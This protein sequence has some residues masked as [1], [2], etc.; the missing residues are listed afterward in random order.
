MPLPLSSPAPD[1][2]DLKPRTDLPWQVTANPDGSSRVFDLD[3]G[4]AT[5]GDA[6]AKFGGLEGLALFEPADGPRVRGV[7]VD[8]SEPHLPFPSRRG[9]S[10]SWEPRRGGSQPL[11]D[12][13]R[14]K[15]GLDELGTTPRR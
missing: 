7:V 6:M 15:G 13:R 11:S 12:H 1:P 8:E 2:A 10:M 3:L 9:A 5:L 14:S 4:S